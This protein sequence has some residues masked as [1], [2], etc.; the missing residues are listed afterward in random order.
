MNGSE[1]KLFVTKLD[2]LA[3]AT[4]DAEVLRHLRV[5][6]AAILTS[7]DKA[8]IDAIENAPAGKPF[9]IQGTMRWAETPPILMVSTAGPRRGPL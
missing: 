1:V 8:G 3:G 6:R 4:T 2:V 9:R 5:N 7:G